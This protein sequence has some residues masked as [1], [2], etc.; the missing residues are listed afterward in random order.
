MNFL[1]S[2]LSRIAAE[3][4]KYFGGEINSFISM[5]DCLMPLGDEH[6]KGVADVIS[7]F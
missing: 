5:L 4:I 2:V 3:N 6:K 1:L 7:D